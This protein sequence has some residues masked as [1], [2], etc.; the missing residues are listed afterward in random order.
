MSKEYSGRSVA[1]TWLDRTVLKFLDVDEA[2]PMRLDNF[3]LSK[4][5]YLEVACSIMY[6]GNY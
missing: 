6:M 1:G 2:I 5:W 4:P 3:K